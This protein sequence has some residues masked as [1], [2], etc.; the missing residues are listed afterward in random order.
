MKTPVYTWHK[1]HGQVID[2]LGWDL[3]VRYS[4][5]ATEHK[6][7]RNTAGMF[8]VSHM[9]RLEFL[10]KDA[11][12]FLN[13]LVPRDIRDVAI[14][15]CA[16][17]YVLNSHG[18]FQDDIIVTHRGENDFMVVCNAGNY[19]KIVSWIQTMLSIM[20][21]M[22]PLDLTFND[23]SSTSAMFALQGPKALEILAKVFE[24]GSVSRWNYTTGNIAGVDVLLKGT[25]YTGEA[26][27]E[28]IVPGTTV[29]EPEKALTV[30]TTIMD[31]GKDLGI[32]PIGLGARDSLRLE[33]GMPLYGQELEEFV[34]PVEAALAFPPFA[35][36]DKDV[37]FIGQDPFKKAVEAGITKIRIGLRMKKRGIPRTH[38]EIVVDGKVIGEV[39]SGTKSPLLNIG[40][41]MGYVEKEY[42]AIGT[43]IFIRTGM[44]DQE[45][46]VVNYPFYDT[47]KYGY[48]RD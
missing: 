48:K 21:Q 45:A 22:H 26:G 46:E 36:I 11:E 4:D 38:H 5:I 14:G 29:D 44:K 20:N 35:K 31:A 32:Q 24:G 43:T 6:A 34:S 33:A 42:S 17:T 2:F 25:G 41:G 16:Y 3:P 8:D 37:T 27:C 23:F 1:E 7:V 12:M 9:G 18:G 15:R 40:F 13:S 19:E 39:T 47:S 10:G 30:W 28:I